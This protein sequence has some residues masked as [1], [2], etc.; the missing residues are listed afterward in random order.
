MAKDNNTS[1]SMDEIDSILASLE[2]DDGL[3]FEKMPSDE[4]DA[5]KGVAKNIRDGFLDSFK[6]N[7]KDKFVKFVDEALPKSINREIDFL[8][9]TTSDALKVYNKS[10]N[11]IKSGVKSTVDIIK[12]KISQD[13]S[14]HKLLSNISGKL[15]KEESFNR[16]SDKPSDD[17]VIADTLK[18][19][20]VIKHLYVIIE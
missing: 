18:D 3:N 1:T 19:L 16:G 15:E 14:L 8:K 20:F 5:A 2:A 12:S 10:A 13:S 11:E 17:D 4:R 6:N 7:P 9:S